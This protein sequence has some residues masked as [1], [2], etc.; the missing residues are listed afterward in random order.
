MPPAV[1][2]V[3]LFNL[4]HTVKCACR[5]CLRMLRVGAGKA[6]IVLHI[7]LGLLKIVASSWKSWNYA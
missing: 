5:G 2:S 6:Q 1:R 4:L 3:G 7:R